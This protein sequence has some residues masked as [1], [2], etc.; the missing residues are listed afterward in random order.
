MFKGNFHV[1][2][3]ESWDHGGTDLHGWTMYKHFSTSPN[4]VFNESVGNTEE[5]LGVLFSSIPQ[6]DV[7]ISKIM[8]LLC[9]LFAGHIEDMSYSKVQQMLWFQTS[10]KVAEVKSWSC[11]DW[12]ETL[13]KTV[14]SAATKSRMWESIAVDFLFI[15]LILLGSHHLGFFLWVKGQIHFTL[16]CSFWWFSANLRSCRLATSYWSWRSWRALVL[17]YPVLRTL[18][19]LLVVSISYILADPYKGNKCDAGE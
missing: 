3:H 6:I 1:G 5:F 7:Q 4:G 12:F 18:K 8:V 2:N 15:T 9:I 11:L 19:L 17:L 16:A 13:Q 10:D 14:L